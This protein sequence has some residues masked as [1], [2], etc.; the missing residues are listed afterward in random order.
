MARGRKLLT[1]RYGLF[2]DDLAGSPG[3]RFNPHIA[4]CAISSRGC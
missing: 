1:L 3:K 2:G 4:V